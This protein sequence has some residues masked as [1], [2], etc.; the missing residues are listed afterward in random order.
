MLVDAF[1][2]GN[3]RVNKITIFEENKCLEYFGN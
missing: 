2:G 1:C 3:Q